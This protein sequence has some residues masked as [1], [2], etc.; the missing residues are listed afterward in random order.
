MVHCIKHG[1]YSRI[2]EFDQF[3]Q[4]NENSYIRLLYKFCGLENNLTKPKPLDQSWLISDLLG[5][6]K[7]AGKTLSVDLKVAQRAIPGLRTFVNYFGPLNN[8]KSLELL[9]LLS[10][11]SN[12]VLP[13][14]KTIGSELLERAEKLLGE[15]NSESCND[16]RSHFDLKRHNFDSEPYSSGIET[17]QGKKSIDA[18]KQVALIRL[19]LYS[20]LNH[21]L[22]TKNDSRQ[23]LISSIQVLSKHKHQLNFRLS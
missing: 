18:F 19:H 1:N 22:L 21:L 3:D 12:E 16:L 2:P 17:G 6:L 20:A 13:G 7:M 4:I 10:Q 5:R 8:P 15:I 23:K 11:I 9:V 14:I